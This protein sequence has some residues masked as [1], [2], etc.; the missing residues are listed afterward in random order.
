MQ[1]NAQINSLIVAGSL[2]HIEQNFAIKELNRY[3]SELNAVAN[4]V[5]YSALGIGERRETSRPRLDTV[6]VK[7][8]KEEKKIAHFRVNGVMRA[9]D[10]MSGQGMQSLA[11]AINAAD[12]SP[13]VIG[14]IVEFDSGGGEATAGDMLSQAISSTKKPVVAVC[15]SCL[16]AAYMAASQAGVVLLAS[17]I[18]E[19]G[20]IGAMMEINKAFV[21]FYK[22]KI[23][24]IYSKKSP[25]KNEEFRAYLD[26][27]KEPLTDLVTRVDEA[28]MELV[29]TSRQQITDETLTGAVFMGDDAI[30]N[31]L[32]DGYGSVE[33]A[34]SIIKK[35]FNMSDT[36]QKTIFQ[37][38][39]GGD[40]E[41]AD[42]LQ[43]KMD[44][45]TGKIESL[46]QRLNKLAG[47]V[48]DL[49]TEQST[50]GTVV[51]ELKGADDSLTERVNQLDASIESAKAT[52]IELDQAVA[53]IGGAKNSTLPTETQLTDAEK[54][55]LDKSKT[56]KPGIVRI[57]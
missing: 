16:S 35:V 45:L 55:V 30:N 52:L 39:F 33:T 37:R 3:F 49:Q 24:A 41:A 46:E 2:W 6:K 26:G 15:H 34:K 20:S 31:G 25:R 54:A 48:T 7:G 29:K 10:G 40:V 38:F 47:D 12:T 22:Q 28:F 32:A 17:K 27:N 56:T 1:G 9:H 44:E 14:H 11:D 13:D 51:S 19:L 57:L 4:G 36:T 42:T 8:G 23:D 53:A 43:A 21:E 50:L 18:S 5:P